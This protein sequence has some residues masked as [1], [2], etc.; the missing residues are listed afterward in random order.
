MTTKKQP[1]SKIICILA[2]C[3]V[4]GLGQFLAQQYRRGISIFAA[5]A[6]ALG[7]TLW[8][9]DLIWILFPILIWAWNI[10]DTTG[11]PKGRSVFLPVMLWL[12]LAYGIGGQVTDFNFSAFR[13]SERV[14][15]MLQKMTNP[16]FFEQN[17]E[18]NLIV[19]NI[20]SP[21]GANP[22][23]PEKTENGKTISIKQKCA[24]V[25]DKIDITGE[26]FWPNYEYRLDWLNPIGNP[27]MHYTGMTDAAGK[28]SVEWTMLPQVIAAIPDPTI[29]QN[30]Q[31]QVVQDR[32]LAGFK[33]SDNGKY[34]LQGIYET[35]AL[36]FL[37]TIIGAIVAVPLGFLAARNL[38]GG[39]PI[40]RTLLNIFRSIEALI[41]AIIFVIIV[42]LGPFPG[43]IALTIHTTAALGKLYSEVIEGIDTGPIEAIKATGAN[44][45][46]VIRYAV[47]PQVVPTFTALTIYRWDINVRSSTIIGFVGG[48][49][50]GFFLYQWIVLQDFRAVGAA[51][52]AIAVVVIILDFV[53]AKI[54][55]KLV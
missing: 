26:G 7:I 51:F 14:V 25:G 31:I 4:P 33:F 42:G 35:L 28:F 40:T 16:D 12:V 19:V 48:G 9:A 46:Q 38:M 10:W 27:V 21:C 24:N 5:F 17:K 20:E 15:P 52:I 30:H 45:A 55:E 22:I 39:N 49:G 43:M 41:M 37:A 23:P 6:T 50:I 18:Q 8:H 29:V 47:I 36:A 1:P 44:W 2:S 34:V 13:N 3:L 32:K 54:R 53:S 11:L